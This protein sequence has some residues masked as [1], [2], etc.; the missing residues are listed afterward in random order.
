M[1]KVREKS[2]DLELDAGLITPSLH[3]FIAPTAVSAVSLG[4][5]DRGEVHGLGNMLPGETICIDSCV[6]EGTVC[7]INAI[8]R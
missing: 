7:K 5:R 3:F 4:I 8:V 1:Y 6:G 2:A